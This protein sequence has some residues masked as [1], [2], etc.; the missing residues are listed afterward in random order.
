MKDEDGREGSGSKSLLRAPIGKEIFYIGVREYESGIFFKYKDRLSNEQMKRYKE[1]LLKLNIRIEDVFQWFFNEY[2]KAEFGVNGFSINM[3]SANSMTLEKC[4]SIS[5]EMDG[6]LKQYRMYAEDHIIDRELFEI[7][8]QHILFKDV[9]S[10]LENKYAYSNSQDTKNEQFFLFSNQS[11][12]SYTE[13]YGDKFNNFFQLITSVDVKMNDFSEFQINDIKWLERRTSI[14][15][16]EKGIIKPNI[17][18]CILLQ[19]LYKHEVI[20][21][22]YYKSKT[23]IDKMINSKD[24]RYQNSLFSIPEQNYLNYMLNKSEYSNGKDLRN[25][26]NHITYSL[27]KNQQEYDY[28]ELLKIMAIIIIKINEEFDLIDKMNKSK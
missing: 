12:L 9:P 18:R 2:L 6:I 19:D 25:K 14:Y 16:D 27:D 10:M 21:P 8:S 26:Y 24:L 20:R 3:P 23:E 1:I 5:S 7:S 13:K 28:N 11:L 4:K 17:V 22:Y 15:I